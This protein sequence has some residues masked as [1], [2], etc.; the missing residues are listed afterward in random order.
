MRG[1][2]LRNDV[3]AEGTPFERPKIAKNIVE[4]IGATP[5]VEKIVLLAVNF[6]TVFHR[7]D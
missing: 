3:I 7:F 1:G 6:V 2:A 4:T 5:M